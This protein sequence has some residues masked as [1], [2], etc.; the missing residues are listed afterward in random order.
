MVTYGI[1]LI[2]P[3]SPEFVPLLSQIPI[4]PEK[5][6]LNYRFDGFDPFPVQRSL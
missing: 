2:A 6:V 4:V 1:T 5:P 3:Y